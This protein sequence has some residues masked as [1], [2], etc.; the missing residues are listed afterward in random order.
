MKNMSLGAK[1]II[2]F[3]LVGLIPFGIIGAI[4][5]TKSSNALSDAAYGQLK[6]MRAVKKAQITQF[7]DERK[8]DMGVLVETV[9]TLRKDAF[10]KLEA[11]QQLKK[12]AIETYFA[13]MFL[14]MGVFAKGKD[15]SMLYD[16]LVIYHNDMKTSPTGNYDVS[17]QEYKQIWETL[18][19]PLQ[20]FYK[21]SGVYDVFLICAKHGHVMYSA[22][23][24][25]DLGENMQHG[26]YKESGLGD[27]HAK[28]VSSGEPAMV[29]MAPYAPSDGDPAI[30]AG[31]PIKKKSGSMIGI[32]AF[33]LPLD[34]INKV[35]ASRHGM[36][37]TGESYLVG[38][39]K[40]MRSDSFLDP[41]NHTVKASFANP[42]KG[43]A[44]TEAIQK[45]LAGKH[46]SGVI[47]DYNGNPVLSCYDPVKIMD[48]NWAIITEIDVAE[49]FCPKDEKG[50]YF[51]KKY[52][53][54][55]GYY[56]LFLINPD[57]YTFYTV[58][59]EADYQTNFVNGK[60]ANSGL[61]QLVRDTISSKQYGLADFAPYAPSNNEPCGF[62]A[63]PVLHNDKVE[64]VVALQLSL[65]AINGIMQQ[66]EGMGET[67]ETYLVGSDKLMRS[68]SFLDPTNHSVKASFAKPSV[69]SVDTE[70]ARSA[71]SGKEDA[72]I[73]T[74]Y[75]GNPVLSAF[76]P[77]KVGNTT[78]ALIAEI[79]K[80]EAFAAVNTIKWLILIISVIAIV[81][82]VAVAWFISRSISKPINTITQGM[83]EGANQVASAAG[84]VSSASQSLAEGSSEQAASIEET[85]SSMEEM[86][87]MTKKNAENAGHANNLM[88]EAN[89][90]VGTANESMGE[91]TTSME[92]I[93]K[94]SEETQK[95]IKT[96]DE[97][98]FQTNLLALNAAV[99]AAR[100]GEAGAGFAV[101]ADEVRNLAMRAA[102]A[103]KDTSEL[104][105]DT[106]K[107][108]GDGSTLVETTN[109]AFSKVAESSGKVG[110][111]VA[112]I[113]EAS[114][115]QSSGIE[116]VNTA[117]SEMDKV[118]QQN[119]ANAEE[120]ASASEEMSAQAETLKDYV[121]DLVA[122]VTGKRNENSNRPADS[123]IKTISAK[124]VSSPKQKK[125]ALPVQ[126]KE[127]KP[128]QVIPFDDDDDFEDF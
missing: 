39:D 50:E 51:F 105:E 89:Q 78:W 82:I 55:Y 41:V 108:V 100:A 99:E 33:Q 114:N 38:N 88:K 66:R 35:M 109:E 42:D 96:I 45:A 4:S 128:D 91:L 90:V 118:V 16:R 34:Q 127:V 69:G 70:A 17:T 77:L 87:S 119:A 15:V 25:K 9:T 20:E 11:I 113:S 6:G 120:S 14:K 1:L 23:K 121:G 104:I 80:S 65:G 93:T 28:I 60:Y 26:K 54:M 72:K 10:E 111:L 86:S 64:I 29:D 47:L 52:T 74:D 32:V 81:A 48:M 8:G 84:Q 117:V 112:E 2:F 110:E 106:M 63:Q 83:D 75:N 124:A 22:A 21:N 13:D 18:G 40:L 126:T 97:I 98:A 122:L 125:K 36:G 68:D 107:K 30:F 95:I 57:G 58:A 101:V 24:E 76:S 94:A 7:F 53:D 115:E 123:H 116:Q 79:D 85:S 49:A 31:Y 59:Q 19:A 73:I 103:A 102:D 67:G 56:D 5:Y 27:L 46:G 43:S 3:L 12:S 37:E 71:L 62:I 44:D 61:G 92:E